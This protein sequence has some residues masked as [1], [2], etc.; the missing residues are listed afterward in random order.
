VYSWARWI[1]YLNPI[2]YGFESVIVNEFNGRQFPCAQFI[3]SG[4]SYE[5]IA[6]EQR[7]CAVK[8]AVAG[9]DYVNGTAFASTTYG[10]Q[11]ANRWR[12]FGIIVVFVIGLCALHLITS[13][14]V[15]SARSKGEVLVFRRKNLKAIS[16]RQKMDE[17]TGRDTAVQTEKYTSDSDATSLVEKQ[18]SIFHWEDVCYEVQIKGETRKILQNV[19]GWVKPGTLTALSKHR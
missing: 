2:S 13:E 8:G 11:Y 3:P 4:P 10:Y 15:A 18:Q 5:G 1:R 6:P 17:E 12:N 16:K 7:A 14:L 19:D 9:A